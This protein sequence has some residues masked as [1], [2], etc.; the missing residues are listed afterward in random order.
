[1]A[2]GQRMTTAQGAV[3]QLMGRAGFRG[4]LVCRFPKLKLVHVNV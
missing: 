2:E 3:E 1:M 4:D